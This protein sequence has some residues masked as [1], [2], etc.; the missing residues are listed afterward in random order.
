MQN[1]PEQ[2]RSSYTAL[3][4]GDAERAADLCAE[5]VTCHIGGEHPFSGEYRGVAQITGVVREMTAVAGPESF[6]VTSLMRDDDGEQVLIEGVAQHGTF[7]RHVINRLRY[8]DGRLA[9]V[10]IK[11]LDQRA[12]DDFWIGRVPQQRAGG[13]TPG[14]AD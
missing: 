14:D 12:E 3:M 1:L 11:P 9:E 7:V 13:S 5:D 8:D 2:I 10:W 6:T 4:S